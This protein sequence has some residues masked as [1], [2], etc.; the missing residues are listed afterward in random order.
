MNTSIRCVALLA[1]VAG[2]AGCLAEPPVAPPQGLVGGPFV[3]SSVS[4]VPA[5]TAYAQAAGPQSSG[6]I[7]WV[8][9]PEGS[10]PRANA[11]TIRDSRSGT[12]IVVLVTD[13]GFDPVAVPAGPSDT[14]SI[15]IQGPSAVDSTTYSLLVPSASLPRIVRSEPP[16]HKRDVPLNVTIV[17]TFSEPMDSGSLMS[18]VT[19]TSGGVAVGGNVV[20]PVQD[21]GILRAEFMPAGPL[22]SSQ[23]YQLRVYPSAQSRAD[24]N[25]DSTYVS[26]F[27][28]VDST[29][30]D[31]TA[32]DSTPPHGPSFHLAVNLDGRL[33]T[34][35][36]PANA[37]LY[38]VQVTY[39]GCAAGCDTTYT[40]NVTIGLGAHPGGAALGGTTTVQMVNGTA[41]FSDLSLSLGGIYSFV[42]SA[43]GAVPDTSRAIEACVTNCWEWRT[44][45]T[46][47][48]TVVGVGVVGGELYA[49]GG[50]DGGNAPSAVVEAYD[51]ASDTWT[52]KASL[53]IARYGFA[54]GV[55]NGKIYAAGGMTAS[56]ATQT[57][58]SYDP[59][60]DS[61]S[62]RTSLPAPTAFPAGAVLNGTLYV[63]GGQSA[64]STALSTVLT[65]DPSTDQWSGRA[66]LPSPLSLA[67][68][69]TLDSMLY[70]FGGSA[71]PGIQV[72]PVQVYSPATNQWVSRDPA[73][74]ASVGGWYFGP[75]LLATAAVPGLGIIAFSGS[76]GTNG[77]LQD[78]Y[79]VGFVYDPSLD[80]FTA[81]MQFTGELSTAG[82]VNGEVYAV[83]HETW[84]FVPTA[85]PPG[86]AGRP[87]LRRGNAH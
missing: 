40:G 36:A 30:V 68:A 37:I 48:R 73:H 61:W 63:I 51:P 53:H 47:R 3:V 26:D 86:V 42:A 1:C 23:A 20:I 12:R 35:P 18:A 24:R 70:V 82:V 44:P 2:F 34:N 28:A 50:L 72:A 7:V 16:P 27:T 57:V 71:G 5:V 25:L 60:T 6:S 58:E 62:I 32:V 85:P 49:I 75:Q 84:R 14:I 31:S 33:V 4:T 55:A 83:G 46:T 81:E 59:T 11:A 79:N 17:V 80:E 10:I 38:P 39:Q 54:V 52:P 69:C 64:D 41:T 77:Y 74:G 66:P 29:A 9:L 15:T 67:A 56:G 45:M 8:S 65:Y 43:P 76:D 78:L 22:K 19:L 87:R 13:G 21:S